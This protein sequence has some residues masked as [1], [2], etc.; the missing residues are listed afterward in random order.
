MFKLD[1][2]KNLAAMPQKYLTDRKGAGKLSLKEETLKKIQEDL[3]SKFPEEVLS[4][5]KTIT[6]VT[7]PLS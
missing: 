7:L 1:M 4:A 2:L 5:L 6:T 3:A